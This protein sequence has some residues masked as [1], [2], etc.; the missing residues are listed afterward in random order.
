MTGT[1]TKPR[2]VTVSDLNATLDAWVAVRVAAHQARGG[3]D[4]KVRAIDVPLYLRLLRAVRQAE[5]IIDPWRV[6]LGSGNAWRAHE[7]VTTDE[8]LSLG[9]AA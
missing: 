6:E 8:Q 5:H 9:V 4:A 1:R 3:P 2:P 7:Y